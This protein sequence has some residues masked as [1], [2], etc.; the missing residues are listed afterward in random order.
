MKN[1]I[2]SLLTAFIIISSSSGLNFTVKASHDNLDTKIALVAALEVMTGDENGDLNLESLVSRAEFAKIAVAMSPYRNMVA[3]GSS[4]SMFTDVNY[5]HWASPYVRLSV[6]NGIFTGYP[7]GTFKPD[8]T[9]LLEEAVTVM[10]RLTGYTDEDFGNSW[11][12]GQ[13]GIAKGNHILDGVNKSIGEEL[14]REDILNIAYNTLVSSP[15][16]ASAG[17]KYI[18]KLN[19]KFYEDTVIIAT[20][21]QNTG[22]APGYVKTSNGTFKI[23]GDFDLSLVGSKGSLIVGSSNYVEGFVKSDSIIDKLVVYTNLDGSVMAYKDG[24]VIKVDIDP[25]TVAY[26]DSTVTTYQS[27]SSG[28]ET[29]DTI[30]VVK[31]T[32]GKTQYINVESDSMTDASTVKTDTWYSKFTN[33]TSTLKV[34]RDGIKSE[35]G[36]I[37]TNDIVYYIKDINTVFAYSKKITGVYE[38]SL[39]NKDM[40]TSVIIS[41]TEYKIETAEAFNKLSSNGNYNLGDTITVMLGKNSQIA[42]VMSS[43]S[44]VSITGFLYDTGTKLLQNADGDNYTSAYASLVYA[45]GTTQEFVCDKTYQ[46]LLN[47]VV[48]VKVKDGVARLTNGTSYL[49]GTVDSKSYTIGTHAVSPQADILDVST[50]DNTLKATYTSV[51]IQR[52]DNI[53]LSSANVLYYSKN[54]KGEID[55]LIL[56]NATGDNYSYGIIS[57]ATKKGTSYGSPYK[58]NIGGSEIM[59]SL[60]YGTKFGTGD[61]VGA[62]ISG[63]GVNSLISLTSVGTVTDFDGESATVSGKEYLVSDEIQIYKKQIVGG[64]TVIT[65]VPL[66][67]YKENAKTLKGTAY[68]DKPVTNGG[69]IRIIVIR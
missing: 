53:K 2:I 31:N 63:G 29:G 32:L 64:K 10:L 36:D 55:S 62:A 61:P 41:G 15:K 5:K 26:R 16:Q 18:D 59:C 7:D 39:P 25:D 13:V 34:L 43:S 19:C 37:K 51:Y 52:L 44:A 27:I 21:E 69:R 3:Q 40:P 11:P 14:S 6:T 35:I 58:L 22:V 50:N 46:N 17:D 1:R 20:N 65:V 24:S 23:D 68:W 42:D 54:Q 4:T 49:N 60:N 30:Y 38:K 12:Y 48:S 47:S 9:V 45:D 66:G 33:D 8:N 56:N 67:E 28:L 57:E